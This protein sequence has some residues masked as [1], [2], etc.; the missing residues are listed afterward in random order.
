M[1]QNVFLFLKVNILT[2]GDIVNDFLKDFYFFN[3]S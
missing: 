1:I 3:Y 2:Y